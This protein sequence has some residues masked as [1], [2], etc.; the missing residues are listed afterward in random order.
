MIKTKEKIQNNNVL[1][2]IIIIASLGL[3]IIFV[4][5]QLDILDSEYVFFFDYLWIGFY[6]TLFSILFL[7]KNMG[8]K[9][10]ML[11]NILIILYGLISSLLMGIPGLIYMTVK[12]ILPFVPEG[13]IDLNP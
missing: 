1:K 2:F 9:I 5:T 13:W 3:P 7:K 12:M 4:L 8:I 11:I 6:S 10:L